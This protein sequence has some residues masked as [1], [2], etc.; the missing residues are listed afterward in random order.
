MV[1][2][3]ADGAYGLVAP[4][5]KVCSF[6]VSREH[7]GLRYGELLLKAVF[8]HAHEGSFVSLYVTVLEKQEQLIGLFQD[9]GFSALSDQTGLNEMVLAKRMVPLDESTDLV[10]L[11]YN[12]Q[13]GPFH[14][15]PNVNWHLVPIE[16]RYS[17]ALFPESALIGSL[18]AGQMAFGNAIRKAYL[19]RSNTRRIRTGDV[20]MFYRSHSSQRLVAIGVV[21]KVVVSSAADEI[22]QAVSRRTVYPMAE[23]QEWCAKPVLTILFRQ[24]R[25]L[26]RHIDTAALRENGVFMAPPQAIMQIQEEGKQWLKKQFAM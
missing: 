11:D 24:A 5:L 22:A 16:P 1:K 10:G 15:D 20:L 13:F 26:R 14:F 21:E 18:F 7:T 9:F 17:D 8:D 25:V 4:T 12:V 3:E 19:C 6:K 2:P 23:I